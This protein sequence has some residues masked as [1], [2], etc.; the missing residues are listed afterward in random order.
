MG[1]R[2]HESAVKRKEERKT[3][4]IAKLN[5]CPSSPRKMCLVADLIRG[6][7]ANKAL[8]TLQFTR[9]E[10]AKSMEKLLRSAISNYEQK[11]GLRA[12]DSD[13]YVSAVFV[14]GGRVLKRVQPAPQ[15]RAHRIRKRSNHV[16]LIVDTKKAVEKTETVETE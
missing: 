9:K 14:D 6:M 16:T 5:N 13:L 7:D 12:N 1:S 8:D 11:S 15:G 4:Y 2:K 10:A 3:T